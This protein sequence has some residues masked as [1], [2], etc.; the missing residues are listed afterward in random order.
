MPSGFHMLP[1]SNHGSLP[2]HPPPPPP[3]AR[4]IQQ[5]TAYTAHYDYGNVSQMRLNQNR[6]GVL[7]QQL[8]QAT[9]G[10]H[11][12]DIQMKPY[13]TQKYPR[14]QQRQQQ[15]LHSRITPPPPPPPP[16]Q[17]HCED[18][19]VYLDTETA[20]E[21]HRASHTKC[22]ICGFSAAPKIVKS[23]YQAVHGKF[24]GSGFKTIT[25]AVPGCPVQRFRICVGN[26]PEDVQEW[27]AERKKRFPRLKRYSDN[28]TA[29]TPACESKE[30]AFSSLLEGY[31]AS[32][33]ELSNDAE[34]IEKSSSLKK[35]NESD[36]VP[37]TAMSSSRQQPESMGSLELSSSSPKKQGICRAFSQ[38]GH[39]QRGAS[40]P[41]EHGP[42][43]RSVNK[44]AHQSSSLLRKLLQKEIERESV[45]TLQLMKYL[46]DSEF[47]E[48]GPT[49]SGAISPG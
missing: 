12:E 47:L 4:G 37:S 25:V 6:I 31:G 5:Q 17:F 26:R 24:S 38:R 16:P 21:A 15:Q 41:Y 2:P 49:N 48:K 3:G 45:L 8:H 9:R 33:S 22:T 19:D 35:E 40:R 36:L 28:T 1:S 30:H 46:V 34:E 14:Y 39:C 20:F 13:G 11:L 7:P 27:I 29:E 10:R 44:G 42:K 32:D 43:C 18:C 23:H